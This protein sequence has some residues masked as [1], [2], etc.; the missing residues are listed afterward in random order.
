MLKTDTVTARY[1]NGA[2][3]L[4]TPKKRRK[5]NGKT[6]KLLGCTGQPALFAGFRRLREW[7]KPG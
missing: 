5:G 4:E 7:P 3:K 6:L 1:L 2:E